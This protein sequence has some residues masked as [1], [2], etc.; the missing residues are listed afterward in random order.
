MADCPH[1]GTRLLDWLYDELGPPER[2]HFDGHL[3]TCAACREAGAS[4]ASVRAAMRAWPEHEPPPAL[5]AQLMRVAARHALG[6]PVASGRVW[7]RVLAWLKRGLPLTSMHPALAAAA[8]LVLVVGVVGTLRLRGVREQAES[9]LGSARTSVAQRTGEAAPAPEPPPPS[10]SPAAST[11]PTRALAAGPREDA[12]QGQASTGEPARKQAKDLARKQAKEPAWEKAKAVESS[13][14]RGNRGAGE[15]VTGGV[16]Q[17]RRGR[18]TSELRDEGALGGERDLVGK[19]PQTR[20]A[21]SMRD[22]RPAPAAPELAGAPAPGTIQRAGASA[23]AEAV[24]ESAQ[25]RA[26]DPGAPADGAERADRDDRYGQDDR[27]AVED[28]HQ[29][30]RQA[31]RSRACSSA[32]FLG[33]ALRERDEA[34][35]R[36]HVAGDED[37]AGCVRMERKRARRAAEERAGKGAQPAGKQ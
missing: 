13:D 23:N 26:E 37:F 8:T 27:E 19:A 4:L 22:A 18:V 28:L 12:W 10:P 14:D 9:H 36:R 21:G 3:H 20:S 25:A 31:L 11:T 7:A 34:Y 35:Y 16:A 24:D 2:A 1:T 15:G 5:S 32:V 30:L 17:V 33:S 29:R 6:A